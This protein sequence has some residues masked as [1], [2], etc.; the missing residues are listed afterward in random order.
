MG[1]LHPSFD[2][3]VDS[4]RIFFGLCQLLVT[5]PK[6]GPLFS[7]VE[8]VISKVNAKGPEVPGEKRH[9]FLTAITGDPAYSGR[10]FLH[11]SLAPPLSF[12][13]VRLP[14]WVWNEDCTKLLKWAILQ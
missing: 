7:A 12:G 5:F 4:S 9:V 11:L 6:C 13:R 10:S 3:V 1:S 2:F 14:F 8:Q